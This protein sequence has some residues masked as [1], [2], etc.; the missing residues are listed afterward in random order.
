MNLR[1][2]RDNAR[3]DLDLALANLSDTID[4]LP[5]IASLRASHARL[6]AALKDAVGFIEE[7]HNFLGVADYKAAIAAAEEIEL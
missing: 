1:L 3:D 7:N 4:R 6:L 5:N 2:P